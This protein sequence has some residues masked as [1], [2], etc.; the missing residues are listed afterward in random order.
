MINALISTRNMKVVKKESCAEDKT[1]HTLD[2]RSVYKVAGSHTLSDFFA[3]IIRN[4]V[5]IRIHGW[6]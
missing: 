5:K 6:Y 3:A 4:G 2:T 1:R